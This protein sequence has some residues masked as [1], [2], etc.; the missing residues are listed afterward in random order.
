MTGTG[1]GGSGGLAS[2][3]VQESILRCGH[4]VSME[5]VQGTAEA[6]AIFLTRLFHS[7]SCKLQIFNGRGSKSLITS[8]YRSTN[9]GAH[10]N[11]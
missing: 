11:C 2:G 10:V 8:A 4:M 5:L 3:H 6:S 9:N 7:R 1:V